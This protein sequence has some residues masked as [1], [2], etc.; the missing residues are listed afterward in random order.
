MYQFVDYVSY[1]RGNHAFKFG[2]DVRHNLADPS[3]RGAGKGAINFRGNQAFAG[4]TPLEDL[5]AGD[6]AFGDDSI[7]GPGTTPKPVVLCSLDSG[8]LARYSESH[9]ESRAA[10]RLS[11][12][13]SE[14]NNLLGGFDP[15]LGMVQVGQQ[16]SSFYNGDHKNFS[17]RLGLAWDLS[18]K[19]TTVLRAG[20]SLIFNS[21]LAMQTFTGAS[22]NS[23]NGNGGVATVPTG[24]T[25]VV[26]GVSRPAP[27]TSRSPTSPFPE[28]RAHRSR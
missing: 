7:G 5:L 1:L 28:A 23:V 25:I 3:Q 19:G 11:T 6:P 27:A 2:G 15:R 9:A 16:I 26:N 8:R 22:G 24:A 4:S 10:L 13:M 12:P 20:Y 17:P 21:L 14:S 18:G